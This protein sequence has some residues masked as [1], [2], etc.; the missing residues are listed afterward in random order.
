MSDISQLHRLALHL[1]ALA[2]P[3]AVENVEKATG[4][5]ARRV[6][7]TWNDKLYREGHASRTGRAISYDVGVAH[8]FSLFATTAEGV[9]SSSIVAEI[10]PRSGSGKQAGLVRLIENG[11]V[12]NSPQGLGAAALDEHAADFEAAVA[13]AEWAAAREHG[14]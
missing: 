12:N 10:G 7:D 3:Q 14:L 11:S 4:Q 1:N 13:F 6:K 8:D 5:T 2:S 9:K